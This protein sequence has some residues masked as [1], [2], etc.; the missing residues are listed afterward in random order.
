[1]WELSDQEF[2]T[3]VKKMLRPPMDKAQHARTDGRWR[4]REIITNNQKRKKK[5]W[6]RDEK[7]L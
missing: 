3:T 1:M 4:Q 6:E 2:K 5:K 7:S